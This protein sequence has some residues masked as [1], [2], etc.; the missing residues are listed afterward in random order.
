MNSAISSISAVS[1]S[2][3]NSVNT[4]KHKDFLSR[5]RKAVEG[6]QESKSS[7][8]LSVLE[9]RASFL[10]LGIV[11][12]ILYLEG[13]IITN[14]DINDFSEIDNAKIIRNCNFTMEEVY[15]NCTQSKTFYNCDLSGISF[16]DTFFYKCS[17]VKCDLSGSS[18]YGMGILD[19]EASD[20]DFR[21]TYFR[22]LSLTLKYKDCKDSGIVVDN[23]HFSRFSR[24]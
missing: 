11:N 24:F 21:G 5:S 22:C 14:M 23:D 9:E 18:F 13:S 17:F 7:A 4:N 12:S 6:A 20:S 15:S 3:I 8:P 19:C 16:K 1:I 10:P 2:K